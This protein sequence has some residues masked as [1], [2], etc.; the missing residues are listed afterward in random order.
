[1][2]QKLVEVS[3]GF[4]IPT[5]MININHLNDLLSQ[6]LSDIANSYPEEMEVLVSELQQIRLSNA[7]DLLLYYYIGKYNPEL[8]PSSIK[9]SLVSSFQ[10]N[11]TKV[12]KQFLDNNKIY[13]SI[14]E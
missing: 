12:I 13:Y 10:L 1:M 14:Y 11:V 8:I 5:D 9:N 6:V 4:E 7:N 3:V 2:K